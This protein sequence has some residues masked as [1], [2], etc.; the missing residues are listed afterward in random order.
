MKPSNSPAPILFVSDKYRPD[1]DGL[2]ALAVL[3]VVLYHSGLSLMSGGYVGVDVFFVISGYLIT[4]ILL[5]Q[6]EGGTLSLNAF[7]VRRIR[8]IAPAYFFVFA[9]TLIVGYFW[10]KPW[11]FKYL[12]SS[13]K[14]VA[15]SISNIGFNRMAGDYFGKSVEEM[16]LLHMWSLGV[17]EQFYLFFPLIFFIASRF[18][19]KRSSLFKGFIGLGVLSL[20]LCLWWI[21][22]RV[23]D[24]FYLLPYRAWELTIGALLAFR[25]PNLGR[26]Q[27]HMAGLLGLV[28]IV[29]AMVGYGKTTLFPGAAALLPCLGAALVIVAGAQETSFTRRIFSLK[30]LV[31]IGL[32]SYSIYL[33]HWPMLAFQNYFQANHPFVASSASRLM[34]G[35]LSLPLGYL[36][37]R[38]IE[39]PVRTAKLK[40]WP[41]VGAWATLSL[42]FLAL[43]MVFERTGGFSKELPPEALRLLAY[44]DHINPNKDVDFQHP[45]PTRPRLYGEASKPPKLVLWGDSHAL[46]IAGAMGEAAQQHGLSFRFYGQ[47]GYCPLAGMSR[48]GASTTQKKYNEEVL[49][50]LE[51]DT[52]VEKVVLVGRWSVPIKGQTGKGLP[53]EVSPSQSNNDKNVVLITQEDG[54]PFA[55]AQAAETA[56]A[57]Y[58]TNTVNRLLRAGK[59]VFLVYPIPEVGYHVPQSLAQE[60]INGRN[61]ANLAAPAQAVFFERQ[62]FVLHAFDELPEDPALVRLKP[63]EILISGG[64][65]RLMAN[66]QPL[67]GDD[68]HLSQ[69]GATLLNP[70]FEKI[71]THE[72]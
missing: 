36:S 26:V 33:V 44:G 2:R 55:S 5:R 45:D 52:T 57:G 62:A 65:I 4:S 48:L 50:I 15:L 47:A 23:S 22:T 41:L 30:P 59:T 18:K 16:P 10:M 66:N 3:G 1:I 54:T 70:L 60:I 27:S 71:F 19:W 38:W 17:E 21:R 24:C 11:D 63:H 28:L 25:L 58:I 51:S 31:A 72:K 43:A 7:Y 34:L 20:V 6:M 40:P 35:L 12:A 29:G 37:W 14:Y 53:D 9:L 13:S 56:Y 67:Y 69:E 49:R 64:R 32:V 39:Q 42:S 46:A 68:N 8:R 61:P